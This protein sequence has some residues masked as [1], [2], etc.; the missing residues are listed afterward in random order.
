MGSI[1]RRRDCVQR[2]F[3]QSRDEGGGSGGV[4]MWNATSGATDAMG[5]ELWGRGYGDGAMG[6]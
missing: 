5:M 2:D 3:V 4:G 1:R 6:M